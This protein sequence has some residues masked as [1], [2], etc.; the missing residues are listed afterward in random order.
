MDNAREDDDDNDGDETTTTM[1]KRVTRCECARAAIVA[2]CKRAM[3]RS[4]LL[5]INERTKRKTSYEAA[6]A[7]S[8]AAAAAAA[9]TAAMAAATAAMAAATA[10]MAA[11]F[12]EREARACAHSGRRSNAPLAVPSFRSSRLSARVRRALDSECATKQPPANNDGDNDGDDQRRRPTST[13][14]TT[15]WRRARRSARGVR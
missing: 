11:S 7:A 5:P 4:F 13:T 15:R 9:A 12:H 10:A 3:K 8:A 6:A 2:A 14:T 1:T